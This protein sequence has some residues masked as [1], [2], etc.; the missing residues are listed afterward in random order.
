MNLDNISL[1]AINEKDK[2]NGFIKCG[3]FSVQQHVP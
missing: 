1:G 3:N 2:K